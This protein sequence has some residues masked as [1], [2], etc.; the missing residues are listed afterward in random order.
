M[1][2]NKALKK[3]SESKIPKK[4][5]GQSLREINIY[6]DPN[7]HAEIIGKIKAGESVNWINK[8]ICD[9]REWIRG[10]KNQN[11]GYII[12]TEEDGN[13]NFD[14]EKIIETPEKK[15]EAS[16]SNNSTLT[17]EEL[18]LGEFF[19]N[20][21]LNEDDDLKINTEKGLNENSTDSS[22]NN[23][24]ENTTNNQEELGLDNLNDI[25]FGSFNFKNAIESEARQVERYLNELS[26]E[27]EKEQK[28]V[29]IETP[30]ME[31]NPGKEEPSLLKRTFELIAE[32]TPIKDGYDSIFG[33]DLITNEKLDV[34]ERLIRALNIFPP[35]KL[36][37]KA[38]KIK[39]CLHASNFFI[40]PTFLK[41]SQKIPRKL[42]IAEGKIDKSKFSKNLNGKTG[43]KGPKGWYVE[44]D[45][46][47]HKQSKWKL[48]DP[49]GNRVASLDEDF[50]IVG[51]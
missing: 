45:Y 2:G 4:G 32:L 49:K 25:D 5:A 3:F 38:N 24:S 21:I 30:K 10:D 18:Q 51:E 1:A 23:S 27:I 42:L 43:S 35:F 39:K 17:D 33:R 36:L 26:S 7:T 29:T 37:S 47:G 20:E 40:S 50:N 6:K 34:K 31:E 28:P 41:V 44:R 8:S 11:F 13:Y 48:K 46:A 19:K 15:S 9:N 22:E 12:G 16:I 14:V